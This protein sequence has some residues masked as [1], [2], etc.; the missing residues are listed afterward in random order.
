[1]AMASYLHKTKI[2]KAQGYETFKFFRLIIIIKW[3]FGP[4][5]TNCMTQYLHNSAVYSLSTLQN[6]VCK[7]VLEM[8]RTTLV[9][10]L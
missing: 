10:C 5:V 7:E 1:M 6:Y 3:I 8:K 4:Q 2:I 9:Y